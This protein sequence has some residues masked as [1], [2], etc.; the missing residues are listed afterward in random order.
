MEKPTPAPQY[1]SVLKQKEAATESNPS[2]MKQQLKKN[3][4]LDDRLK[5]VYV[6][7]SDPEQ[8]ADKLE[9]TK[10]AKNLPQSRQNVPEFEFGVFEPNVVPE[11]KCTLR[12]AATFIS[13]HKQDPVEHNIDNIAL[14]YKLDKKVVEN[15]LKHFKIFELINIEPIEPEDPNVPRIDAFDIKKYYKKKREDMQLKS[16]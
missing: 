12:H 1:P 6:T 3:I 10:D 2:F 16:S 8:N 14:K 15:V 5:T 7:S 9:D 11:G 4:Q 13:Q